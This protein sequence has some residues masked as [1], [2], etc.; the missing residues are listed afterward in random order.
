MYMLH[1]YRVMVDFLT[2]IALEFDSFSLSFGETAT[3]LVI[4]RE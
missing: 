2:S 1:T 4:Q 3:Q